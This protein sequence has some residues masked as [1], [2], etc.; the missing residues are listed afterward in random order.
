MVL[1]T[2]GGP[3]GIRDTKMLESALARPLN[4][5]G[6][7]PSTS[8]YDLAASYSYGI[9]MNHP[10]VDGNKRTALVCGLVFLEINGIK[11]QASEAEAVVAFE[12]LA[13]GKLSEEELGH[14]FKDH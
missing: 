1:A 5:F 13:A 6:Y 14:W 8:I 2:H 12:S 11:I 4:K 7:E 9:A 3:A 10:F